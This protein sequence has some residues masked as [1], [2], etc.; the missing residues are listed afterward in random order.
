ML[1]QVGEEEEQGD[2]MRRLIVACRRWLLGDERREPAVVS[3]KER[4]LRVFQWRRRG[5][6]YVKQTRYS[7]DFDWGRVVSESRKGAA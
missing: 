2:G 3:R 1:E 5:R 4:R 6:P 7:G